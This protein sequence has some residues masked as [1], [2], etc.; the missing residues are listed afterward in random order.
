MLFRVLL[1]KAIEVWVLQH[2][3]ADHS[4]SGIADVCFVAAAQPLP[5]SSIVRRARCFNFVSSPKDSSSRRVMN[6][7]KGAKIKIS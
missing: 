4:S 7:I 3:T 6:A 2:V 5:L 1:S